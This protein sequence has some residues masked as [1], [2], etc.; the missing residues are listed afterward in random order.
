MIRGIKVTASN[1]TG[2]DSYEG[3]T[4]EDKV[5]RIMQ[6]GEPITDNAPIIYTERKDGVDPM[7]DIRTDRFDI[8]LDATTKIEQSL[9]ARRDEYMKQQEQ[10]KNE[11][12]GDNNETVA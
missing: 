4:I 3:E 5:A 1:M 8:A 12:G 2:I 11:K 9:R 10:S 6:N 7:Y